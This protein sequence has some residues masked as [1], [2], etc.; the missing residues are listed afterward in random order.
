MLMWSRLRKLSV[1]PTLFV[2]SACAAGLMPPKTVSDYCRIAAP[3]MYNSKLDSAPT[4][5]QIEHHN[6]QWV[7]VCENDCPKSK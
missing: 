7:C 1:L 2:T 3:I 5:K 4:V 6:S